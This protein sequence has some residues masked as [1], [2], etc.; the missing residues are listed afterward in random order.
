MAKKTSESQKRASVK[1]YKENTVL[2]TLRLNKKNDS[3]I[4]QYLDS[5]KNKSETIKQLIREKIK[6]E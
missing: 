1:Y 4:I 6:G 2:F 5:L 3:D